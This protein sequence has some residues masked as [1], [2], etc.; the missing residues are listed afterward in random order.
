MRSVQIPEGL[1]AFVYRNPH[2]EPVLLESTGGEG[3]LLV[4]PGETVA[5]SSNTAD[6][7]AMMSVTISAHQAGRP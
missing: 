5:W 1:C 2:S 7:A 4:P 6:L 3:T